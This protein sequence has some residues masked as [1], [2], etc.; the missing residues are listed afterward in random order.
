VI[1]AAIKNVDLSCTSS[2]PVGRRLPEVDARVTIIAPGLSPTSPIINTSFRVA[3]LSGC[4]ALSASPLAAQEPPPG[5]SLPSERTSHADCPDPQGG[6]QATTPD[7]TYGCWASLAESNPFNGSWLDIRVKPVF[8]LVYVNGRY[9]GTA[10]QFRKPFRPLRVGAGPQRVDLRAP[11]Y[12]TVSFW[13][14][15]DTG[16]VA[17]ATGTLIK[18]P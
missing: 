3:A 12:R 4:L 14:N 13:L 7:D 6:G 2:P 10:E 18:N 5:F 15:T 8:A 17:T 1:A 11:G 16:K 9:V